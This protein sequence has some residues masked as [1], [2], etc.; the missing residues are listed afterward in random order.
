MYVFVKFAQ[1]I[2]TSIV[3]KCDDFMRLAQFTPY[4]SDCILYKILLIGDTHKRWTIFQQFHLSFPHV[5]YGLSPETGYRLSASRKVNFWSAEQ[6][7]SVLP[8]FRDHGFTYTH[9][10]KLVRARPDLLL[11][12][13]KHT[14]LPK[15]EIFKSMGIFPLL[16][17]RR[18][19]LHTQLSSDVA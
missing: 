14:L 1:K 12:D 8:L 16:T 4:I 15:L 2:I 3:H 10:S 18:S 7:Y 5:G 9:F 19:F 13:P 17:S 11:A 6:P